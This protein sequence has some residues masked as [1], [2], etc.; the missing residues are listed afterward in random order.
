MH[1]LTVFSNNFSVLN[2]VIF[3]AHDE[4]NGSEKVIQAIEDQHK[5]RQETAKLENQMSDIGTHVQENIGSFEWH[6]CEATNLF[7]MR[8][9]LDDDRFY[10]A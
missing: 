6:F 2:S 3:A 9:E 4:T 8:F 5:H 10:T 1:F 7:E